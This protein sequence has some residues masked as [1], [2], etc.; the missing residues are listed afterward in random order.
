MLIRAHQ[1][2][3]SS[4]D[5]NASNESVGNA[6]P[7]NSKFMNYFS[8]SSK[9]ISQKNIQTD[10]FDHYNQLYLNDFGLKE[11][12]SLDLENELDY[13]LD[14]ELQNTTE[15]NEVHTLID[16]SIKLF[17]GLKKVSRHSL[18]KLTNFR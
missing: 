4:S 17:N 15:Q 10:I 1:D 13:L 5:I 7:T 18:L 6:R 8:K 2:K 3:L 12:D 11:F 16:R 9:S 14:I